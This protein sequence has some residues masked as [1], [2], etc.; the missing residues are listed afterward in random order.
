[1]SN[2]GRNQWGK[3]RTLGTPD[4]RIKKS[5][6]VTG[7]EA[8]TS[9][10]DPRHVRSEQQ[11]GREATSYTPD[12]R[13]VRPPEVSG[14]EATTYTPDPRT[15]G[16]YADLLTRVS[17]AQSN[18]NYRPIRLKPMYGF[19]AVLATTQVGVLRV[20][21]KRMASPEQIRSVLEQMAAAG[22]SEVALDLTN[23][24]SP[25]RAGYLSRVPRVKGINKV[26][27]VG[28]REDEIGQVAPNERMA[29]AAARSGSFAQYVSAAVESLSRPSYPRAYLHETPIPGLG[30]VPAPERK[31]P[32]HPPH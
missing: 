8:T 24:P 21:N 15:G 2:T 19:E 14:R 23:A 22:V 3:E 10:P 17:Q 5:P 27:Y 31:P 9:T 1:M 4:P 12:P 26:I 30:L 32:V 18:V 13:H 28:I 11:S 7:R 20:P 29:R 16:T 6:K 25:N